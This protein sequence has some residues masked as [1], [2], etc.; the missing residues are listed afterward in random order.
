AAELERA[1]EEAFPAPGPGWPDARYHSPDLMIAARS[2]EELERGEWLAVM[3]ELHAGNN[4]LFNAALPKEHDDPE[5]LKAWKALDVPEVQVE[6]ISPKE[7]WGR[8][9]NVATSAQDVQV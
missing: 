7:Q 8:A 3:G 2:T 9:D 5:A 6:L 1:A 4:T